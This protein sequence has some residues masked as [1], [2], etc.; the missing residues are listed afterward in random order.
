MPEPTITPERPEATVEV[1]SKDPKKKDPEDA[2]DKAAK[3]KDGK[4]VKEGEEELVRT[5][6]RFI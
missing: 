3:P 4:E 1:P 5:S 2:K 6:P